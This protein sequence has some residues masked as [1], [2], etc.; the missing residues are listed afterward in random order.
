[1]K[2]VQSHWINFDRL[3]SAV[4]DPWATPISWRPQRI[5]P[6]STPPVPRS[7][8]LYQTGKLKWFWRFRKEGIKVSVSF[9][10]ERLRCCVQSMT[11][12][13]T[14][15]YW[16]G[17]NA[18]CRSRLQ[19]VSIHE[20]MHFLALDT[21]GVVHIFTDQAVF[22]DM[23]RER[24]LSFCQLMWHSCCRA[25]DT[26]K[27]NYTCIF[28]DKGDKTRFPLSVFYFVP[29]NQQLLRMSGTF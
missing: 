22:V 24:R 12:R 27:H 29:I 5:Y 21:G 17:N 15:Y 28:Q 25:T 1:M 8:K 6:W 16:N 3:P 9:K 20:D 11:T 14:T 13:V 18:A 2:W 4:I 7:G 19:V 23:R 10:R 26:H